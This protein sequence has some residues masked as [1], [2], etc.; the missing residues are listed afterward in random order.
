MLKY[1][2]SHQ[3][4]NNRFRQI[5]GQHTGITESRILMT[6]FSRTGPDVEVC[7]AQMPD[8]H[9]L[10]IH[11]KSDINHHLSGYGIFFEEA[12]IRLLGESIERYALLFG[13]I[14]YK[15][16]TVYKT[17]NEMSSEQRC[18]QWEHMKM[19]SKED[20]EKIS[21]VTGVR[22]IDKDALIAWVPCISLFSPGQKINIPTQMLF[23]G[24]RVEAAKRD[25]FFVPGF[26][27]G[28]AAHTNFK[29]ALTSAMMEAVEAHCFMI[30]WYTNWKCKKVI[31]D[32]SELL[33][34]VEKALGNSDMKLDV[35]DYSLE[36]MPGYTFAAVLTNKKK[37]RPLIVVGCQSGLNPRRTL[38][39]ALNEALAIYYLAYNGP[40]MLPEHYLQRENSNS[41]KKEFSNLD[42]NV[43]YW[44][45]PD[46]AEE[47]LKVFDDKCKGTVL[48]SSMKDYSGSDGEELKYVMRML[49]KV[50]KDGVFLDITPPEIME[51]GFYV[52]RTF[53]PELVQLSLPSFPFSNHPAIKQ[54]GGIANAYPH[55]VP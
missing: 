47:K 19:Y 22:D 3:N 20:Y 43:A 51:K 55:P 9:K 5:S 48:L 30:N 42:T 31:I 37:K 32:D 12:Y 28:T 38:Y 6:C 7:T 2:P 36:D 40:L 25:A 17:Y 39:R 53:F 14:L 13:A 33:D 21:K 8:Y 23:T 49:S 52:L 50:S 54:Y 35:Y 45:H 24:F 46:D 41:K 27:K 34:I 16:K 11:E 4:L 1:Y 29:K 10:I 44:A 15:N 18:M 26:S